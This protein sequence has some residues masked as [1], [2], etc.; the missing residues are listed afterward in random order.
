MTGAV[1]LFI[2]M[3]LQFVELVFAPYVYLA[4]SILFAY[5]QVRSG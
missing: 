4:G 5:V 2:G 1:L 3:A